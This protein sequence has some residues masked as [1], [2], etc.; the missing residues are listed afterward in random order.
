[1]L[2][3]DRIVAIWECREDHAEREITTA[4]GAVTVGAPRV[5]DKRT[6]PETW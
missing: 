4:A 2:E 6:D 5:N 3:K 1:M